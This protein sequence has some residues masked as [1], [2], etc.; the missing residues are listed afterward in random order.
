MTGLAMAAGRRTGTLHETLD[1]KSEDWLD[2]VASTRALVGDHGTTALEQANHAAAS[3]AFGYGYDVLRERLP[4]VPSALL[5]MLYG[6]GL[7]A[8]NIAGIAPVLGIT[9]GEQHIFGRVRGE[10][11]GLHVLYGFVTAVVAQALS[12]RPAAA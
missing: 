10:R 12:R 4:G 3:A 1:Q 2:R 9:E 8:A 6:C 11:L 5:G 7:Y